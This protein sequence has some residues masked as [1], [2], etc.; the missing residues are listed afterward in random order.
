MT[1]LTILITAMAVSGVI[2]EGFQMALLQQT[3]ASRAFHAHTAT[4]KSNE[5]MT[6][7]GPSGLPL[8]VEPMAWPLRRHRESVQLS[9]ESNCEVGD[10]DH[11]LDL[12]K[13]L[14]ECLA[15]FQTDQSPKLCLVRAKRI[16]DQ[17]HVLA[18]PWRRCSAPR[19]EGFLRCADDGFVVVPRSSDHTGQTDLCC[20]VLRQESASRRFDLSP[21]KDA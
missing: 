18:A 19:K 2:G 17:P 9:G 16:P 4:G 21:S 8:F 3:A 12:A 6:P 13:T 14:R 11:L 15:C 5:V 7:M 1:S 10:I 20:G